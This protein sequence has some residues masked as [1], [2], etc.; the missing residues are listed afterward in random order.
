[1]VKVH[2]CSFFAS[3]T[4]KNGEKCKY[5]HEA[6]KEPAV[7]ARH[8]SDTPSAGSD[9]SC[10]TLV[11][12]DGVSVDAGMSGDGL[13]GAH[14]EL[15]IDHSAFQ[16]QPPVQTAL[17]IPLIYPQNRTH[18]NYTGQT[19]LIQM[20]PSRLPSASTMLG[21]AAARA[22]I[23]IFAIRSRFKNTCYCFTIPNLPFGRPIKTRLRHSRANQQ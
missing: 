5:S 10:A 1:M 23:V 18:E 4:C 15:R 14:R 7:R 17:V 2:T 16:V 20:R 6:A 11:S 12:S 22:G 9:D 13:W 8:D 3:G 19:T 21:A